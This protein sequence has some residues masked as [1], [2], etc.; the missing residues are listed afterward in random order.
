MDPL[1]QPIPSINV[2]GARVHIVQ[3]PEVLEILET[4][5]EKGVSGRHVV[6]TGMHGA[7]ESNRDPDFRRIVNAADL[8]VAD[9]ISLVWIA[10]LRGFRVKRRVS[11]ADLM[12][13][14]FK[15]AQ[16]RGYKSFFYGDTE[17]TLTKLTLRLK[18]CFPELKIAGTY[19]PPFR[20]LNAAE[21]A[22]QVEMINNSGADV[23]WVGLGL[24]KQER[25][26]NEFKDS[27]NVPVSIGVGAAFRFISGQTVRAP[28]WIGNSGFEWLWRLVHQPRQVWRRILVDGP[29]FL[30]YV[31]LELLG[32]KKTPT[33][34]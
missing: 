25:W 31:A 26:I 34:Q 14:F 6:V 5:I 19:S 13:E 18:Q 23:L 30:I 32:L 28:A 12:W 17:E 24:P 4:W 9:G 10:R 15:L 16:E 1:A 8:F 21:S 29:R 3:I 27:L 11:G 33:L 22:E 2:L 20:S 7:M